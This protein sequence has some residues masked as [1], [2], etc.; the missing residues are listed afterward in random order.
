MRGRLATEAGHSGPIYH[1]DHPRTAR[2]ASRVRTWLNRSR[3]A[4]RPVIAGE[5]TFRRQEEDKDAYADVIEEAL[6]AASAVS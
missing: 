5:H 4:A 6:A 3:R 1:L 2:I